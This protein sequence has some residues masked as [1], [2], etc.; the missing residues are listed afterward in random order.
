MSCLLKPIPDSLSFSG[1]ANQQVTLVTKD[2]VGT[3]LIAKAEYNDQQLVPA[4][5]AQSSIQLTIA[6][7]MKSLKIVCVFTAS[8]QGVGELRESAPPDSQ[9]V[10]DLNGDE[11]FQ[12]IRI[13][14]V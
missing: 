12:L 2:H 4:G 8:I 11:P 10:R 6:Q 1:P 13:N 7:G 14:G 5:Q 3:V 9:F